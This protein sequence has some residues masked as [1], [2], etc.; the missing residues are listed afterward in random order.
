MIAPAL[1]NEFV[2]RV[3]EVSDFCELLALSDSS[4]VCIWGAAGIGKSALLAR[5]I[6]E[7]EHRGV[8]AVETEW[9][10]SR[11]YSYLDLMRRI[12]DR[13][14][15]ELFYPFNDRVN[16][17]TAPEYRLHLQVETGTIEHVQVTTGNVDSGTVNVH[18]GHQI[19]IKDF[20]L[21]V[22]RPD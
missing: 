2:D 13:T 19:E 6:Q 22:L 9:R 1:L 16:F 11:R 20:M 14:R 8:R 4:I 5:L 7:C 12:R 17:Y 18:V 3:N 21:N 15:P 10:D